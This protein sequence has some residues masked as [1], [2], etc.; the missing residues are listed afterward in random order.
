MEQVQITPELYEQVKAM[1]LA[2]QKATAKAIA[3]ERAARAAEREKRRKAYKEEKA[4]A[5]SM[6]E[7]TRQKFTPLLVQR[8]RNTFING[9]RSLYDII[10]LKFSEAVNLALRTLGYWNALDAYRDNKADEANKLVG[11]ILDAMIKQ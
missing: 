8:Y 5:Q 2:E 1:V 11:E 9:C 7:E 6:F 10:N 3:E 4:K